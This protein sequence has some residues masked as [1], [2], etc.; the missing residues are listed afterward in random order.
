MQYCKLE[1]KNKGNKN[2]FFNIKYTYSQPQFIFFNIS[3]NGENQI[4]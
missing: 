3:T 1:G 2:F 4:T